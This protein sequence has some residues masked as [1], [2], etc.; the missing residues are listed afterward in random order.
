MDQAVRRELM[1]RYRD[2]S[3]DVRA[4]MVGVG[5]ADLTAHPLP[6]EWSI[7]EIVHHL[8]DSELIAANVVLRLVAEDQPDLP[9][10]DEADYARRL[11]YPT[12]SIESSLSALAAIRAS[13]ADLLDRLDESEW[14]RA[15]TQRP[16]GR[17]S[18]EDWLRDYSVHAAEHA[19][20]IRQVRQAATRTRA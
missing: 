14:R 9:S 18:L 5:A 20:Q 11:H 12:R 15:G 7:Q 6:E 17:Y 1:A 10:Y 4:A 16:G 8:A 2:G 19:E 3:R 13:T